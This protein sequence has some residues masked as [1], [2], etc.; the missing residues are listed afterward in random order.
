MI[1][2][3]SQS[4]PLHQSSTHDR[5]RCHGEAQ[6]WLK[7]L[8]R[9]TRMGTSVDCLILFVRPPVIVPKLSLV[10]IEHLDLP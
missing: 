6:D 10:V 8:E 3:E 5:R 1:R 7:T 2:M 4:V 9:S